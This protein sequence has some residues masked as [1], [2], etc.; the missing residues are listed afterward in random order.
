MASP[1]KKPDAGHEPPVPARAGAEP[2]KYLPGDVIAGKYRL[3]SVIGEGGMGS[4]WLAR[5]LTLDADVCVK[6][7]RRESATPKAAQRL[8]QEARATARLNHP[9]IVRVFDFGETEHRDPFIVMELLRGDS[10]RRLISRK[11]RLS[12]AN[13]VATLLPVASGLAEAHSKGVVH[14]DLKP[15]NVVLVQDE[16]GA[17]IPKVVDFGV[18]KMR[19][20][21]GGR[22]LTQEG[23]VLGSPD[24]MSPEQAQGKDVDE[25][26]DVW[27]FSVMLYELLVGRVPFTG[28]NYNALLWA[29]QHDPPE[30][31]TSHA[32]GDTD[33]WRIV[34]QGLEKDRSLRWQ[35]MRSMG[36]ALAEWAVKHQID[37]DA[38]GASVELGW[39]AGARR[40]L[41]EAPRT[42]LRSPSFPD[43]EGSQPLGIDGG[44][45]TEPVTV[46]PQRRRL[47]RVLAAAA[48]LVCVLAA[49]GWLWSRAGAPR[50]PA[51]AA[52]PTELDARA[53]E[54]TAASAVPPAPSASA[55]AGPVERPAPKEPDRLSCVSPLF[56]AGTFSD[57][58]GVD[59]DFL[60][61]ETDP[62]IGAQRLKRQV[63]SARGAG[64]SAGMQEWSNLSWYEMAGFAIA[65]ARCCESPAQLALPDT[66][67][68]CPRLD[69]ALEELGRSAASGA[70]TTSAVGRFD[71]AVLCLFRKGGAKKYGYPLVQLGEVRPTFEKT[72][73]R[74]RQAA[75]VGSAP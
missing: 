21:G 46:P 70:D 6:L 53:P 5:N 32:A 17:V 35:S 52:A 48:V 30:P 13:A 2:H 49:G 67:G 59:L 14:R 15:E 39:L 57:P 25:R 10:L 20:E 29:I 56:P 51:A 71:E 64:V 55:E 26:S 43:D 45:R 47:A 4:V 38:T 68:V 42:V 41:S 7:I 9:S 54:A 8:L 1:P 27:A 63:V 34:S 24:Y 23:S 3:T 69:Q 50:G 12:A 65:R 22:A 62:R 40:P 44:V 73:A 31:T 37:V 16:S 75:R 72:L 66:A 61:T 11:A 60:C 58:R 33:L 18:A 74:A 19:R 36:V 28:D